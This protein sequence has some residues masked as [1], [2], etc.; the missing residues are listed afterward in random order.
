MSARSRASD[1]AAA[2]LVSSGA[3]ESREVRADRRARAEAHAVMELAELEAQLKRDDAIVKRITKQTSRYPLRHS[4]INEGPIGAGTFVRARNVLGP[5]IATP[6]TGAPA[7]RGAC[8]YCG[9]PRSAHAA[10][11]PARSPLRR[12]VL[13]PRLSPLGYVCLAI[14]SGVSG[15]FLSYSLGIL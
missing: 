2:G 5:T 8:V 11:T 1:P 3:G 13:R 4:N 6:T 7:V 14:V 10:P 9:A 15:L 12:S